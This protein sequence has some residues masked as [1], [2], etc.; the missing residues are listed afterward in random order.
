MYACIY[1]CI[2]TY[3]I[4]VTARII[5]VSHQTFTDLLNQSRMADHFPLKDL[6]ELSA[7]VIEQSRAVYLEDSK[8]SRGKKDCI[9]WGIKP[10]LLQFKMHL[11]HPT[12]C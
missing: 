8:K 10:L 2:A 9:A 7:T 11:H 6:I 4:H 12:T 1:A 5:M 3:M